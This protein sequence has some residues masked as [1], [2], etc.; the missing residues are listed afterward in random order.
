MKSIKVSFDASGRVLSDI[1]EGFQH[2][3][4][5]QKNRFLEYV[6]LERVSSFNGYGVNTQALDQG[7]L[8]R[9]YKDSDGEWTW[10]R[11]HATD[12][13]P[14]GSYVGSIPAHFTAT[15]DP[16]DDCCWESDVISASDGKKFRFCGD[17][18]D[19]LLEIGLT[20][21]RRP[22]SSK[23]EHLLR[24]PDTLENSVAEINEELDAEE[25]EHYW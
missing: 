5:S 21:N 13:V 7:E 15:F 3:S 9:F 4:P 19:S 12:A 16:S 24:H 14:T 2:L 6:G 25:R 1:D 17:G 20:G 23:L 18:F 8:I 11:I 22:M 10:E